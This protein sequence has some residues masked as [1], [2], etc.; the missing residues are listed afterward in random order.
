M[1]NIAGIGG[2]IQMYGVTLNGELESASELIQLGFSHLESIDGGQLQV[3]LSEL[4][5]KFDTGALEMKGSI[6]EGIH[7]MA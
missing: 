6:T 5:A 4:G 7:A 1:N 2:D 3:N